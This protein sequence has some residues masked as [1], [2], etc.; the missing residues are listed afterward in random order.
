MTTSD[1]PTQITTI[2]NRMAADDPADKAS[3]EAY[4]ANLEAKQ[5]AVTANKVLSLWDPEN[6]PAWS[7]QRTLEREK[8]RWERALRKRNN[9]Q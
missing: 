9:Y 2:L 6:P 3:L 4:I 5:R 8:R 7:H 1:R